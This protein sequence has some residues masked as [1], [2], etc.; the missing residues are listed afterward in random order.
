MFHVFLATLADLNLVPLF[1]GMQD[2]CTES[3]GGQELPSCHLV[4]IWDQNPHYK[5]KYILLFF[6]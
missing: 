3:P 4:T 2:R 6:V 5:Y 1:V